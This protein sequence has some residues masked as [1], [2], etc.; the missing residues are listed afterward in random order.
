MLLKQRHDTQHNDTRYNDPQHTITTHNSQ[1]KDTWCFL[2]LCWVTRFLLSWSV[3]IC[4]G[5]RFIV[6]LR[7]IVVGLLCW[8][9]LAKC[10]YIE[11]CYFDSLHAKCRCEFCNSVR[12]AFLLLSKVSLWIMSLCRASWGHQGYNFTCF[13]RLRFQCITIYKWWNKILLALE[14]SQGGSKMLAQLW[15][16]CRTQCHLMFFMPKGSFTLRR[17]LR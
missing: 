1:H 9:P 6:M 13:H 4:W 5:S 14:T 12:V 2:S 15:L 8:G 3:S 17:K 11:Y 7:V 10:H 16:D